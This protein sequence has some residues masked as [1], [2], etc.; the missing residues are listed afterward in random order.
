[1]G[2]LRVRVP[3]TTANLGP[4]FDALGLALDLWNETE[5]AQR[6]DGRVV[7]TIRGEG[8]GVLPIDEHNVIAASALRVFELA[9]EGPPGLQIDCHNTIPLASGLGSSA[10]AVLSGLL[11]ANALLDGRFDQDALLKIAIQ[12][13]GH[14]DNVAPAMLGGLV[15]CLADGEQ[16]SVHPLTP[17]AGR[18]PIYI[19]L[20]LPECDFP[21]QA[22]RAVL[23]AQV[24]RQD[25]IF[26][27]SRAV[28][29]AEAL[30]SGDLGLLGSAMDDRLHQPY[31]LPLITGAQAA[32]DAAKGAGA[33][34]VA[35]S[36][37]GPSLAAFSAHRDPA[38]GEAMQAAFAAEGISARA[39]ELR[40]SDAGAEVERE[41]ES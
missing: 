10:A 35:L 28:L 30:L 22:A 15:V 13:E 5:F 27:I 40:P 9:G 26:N 20:V 25:A 18:G 3:A 14:P 37:A 31:R 23:P 11:G 24:D 34:A 36:G 16:V 17:R 4:G 39:F 21:T 12:S 6:A 29:V 41:A 1:M 19:T 33:A 2:K 32:L 8:M 7:V 38:I